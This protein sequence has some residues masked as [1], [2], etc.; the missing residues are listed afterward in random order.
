MH[1]GRR[2]QDHRVDLGLRQRLRQIG[3][4]VRDAVLGG[5]GPGLLR[6]GADHRH[7]LDA[8]NV[9]DGVEM[10]D[11]EGART[12]QRDFDYFAHVFSKI[13]CPTAVLE[14]GTW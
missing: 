5:D 4:H 8:G 10:L 2:A 7:H 14:A 12:G 6:V 9:L 11:A 1:L 3:R 13:R